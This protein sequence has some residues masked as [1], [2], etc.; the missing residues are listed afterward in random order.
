MNA[1]MLDDDVLAAQSGDREAFT[2]LVDGYRNVV[3]SIVTAIL[4]DLQASEDVA[5]EVFVA[6]WTGLGKLRNPASFLPWL[7]QLA[8]NQAHDV[9]RTRARRRRH[10]LDDAQELLADVV[11]PSPS[12]GEQMISSETQQLLAQVMEQL[13]DEARE[14]VTLYYREGRS[15]RQVGELLGLREDAVKK[16]LERARAVLR[17]ELLERFGEAVKQTAPGA[18]FTAA[19]AAAL[20]VAA[21]ASAAAATTAAL[22]SGTAVGLLGKLAIGLTGVGLGL[23]GGLGGIVLGLRSGLRRA[24]DDRE[25][26]ELRKL[27]ICSGLTVV[28]FAFGVHVSALLHSAGLLIGLWLLVVVSHSYLYLVWMPRIVGRRHLAEQ[29]EHAG[30]RARHR[31]EIRNSRLGYAIGMGGG[32][33]AVIYAAAMLW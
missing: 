32:T 1:V 20:T 21:P 25:R 6:A 23:V 30:A 24:R 31:K 16:R 19:V 29:V 7:R 22:A 12:M 18:A 33:A 5:Q 11:D 26:R 14:V 13:P 8:R 28:P 3:C 2:R 15:A 10:Q 9:A 27:A 4:R 17:R